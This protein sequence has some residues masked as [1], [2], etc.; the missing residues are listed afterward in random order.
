VYNLFDENDLNT[1]R[2]PDI[3]G[4]DAFAIMD[5]SL[6]KKEKS[7]ILFIINL[8]FLFSFIRL[9]YEIFNCVKDYSIM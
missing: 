4:I 2:I 5:P 9:C 1:V 7:M 8:C 6:Q 3:T